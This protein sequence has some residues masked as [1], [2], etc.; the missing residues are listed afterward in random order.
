MLVPFP[1]PPP[2]PQSSLA[3]SLP[4]TTLLP[5]CL[6]RPSRERVGLIIPRQLFPKFTPGVDRNARELSANSSSP[7]LFL[8]AS[9]SHPPPPPPLLPLFD[10]SN[11]S[12]SPHR[13]NVPAF[14]GNI[15]SGCESRRKSSREEFLSGNGDG[16]IKNLSPSYS[17]RR[18]CEYFRPSISLSIY[19]FISSRRGKGKIGKEIL[20]P[21]FNS[22]MILR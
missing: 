9:A 22:R 17:G 10:Y 6:S 3:S 21:E 18:Y 11:S 4:D 2:S 16:R 14:A 7:S 1:P 20:R 15:Q 8:V 13:E 19:L 5:S 12:F